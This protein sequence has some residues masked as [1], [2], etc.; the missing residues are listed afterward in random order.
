MIDQTTSRD[1]MSHREARRIP[2]PARP[3]KASPLGSRRR[4]RLAV[5]ALYVGYPSVVGLL[6]LGSQLHRG[7]S[8]LRAALTVPLALSVVAVLVGGFILLSRPAINLPNIADRDLDERQRQVRDR[9]YRIAYRLAG[10]ALFLVSLIT[11]VAL[12][13]GRPVAPTPE[14]AQAAFWGVFIVVTTLPTAIIAWTEPD[15]HDHDEAFP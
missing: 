6:W 9:A 14:S 3:P 1:P 12:S 10:G 2:A 15:P 11:F 13:A 5:L 4:H 7:W 8:P